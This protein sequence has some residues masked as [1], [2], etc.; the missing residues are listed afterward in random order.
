MKI[1][2]HAGL[3]PQIMYRLLRMYAIE[4][5]MYVQVRSHQLL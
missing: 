3:V 2:T 1:S 5:K 4:N